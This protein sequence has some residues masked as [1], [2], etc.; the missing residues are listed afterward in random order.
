VAFS[1]DG[2]KKVYVQ[3]KLWENGAEVYQWLEEGAHFYICGDMKN[4]ARAVLDT[5]QKIVET[6]GLLS[7][8]QAQEYVE[9]LEKAKRLQQDVY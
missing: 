5:L 7:A 4:M 8:E 2:D 6:Y 3:D 1:R 9:D